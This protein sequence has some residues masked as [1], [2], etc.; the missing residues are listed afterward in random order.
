MK[1]GQEWACDDV[2]GAVLDPSLV[3]KD[4][5]LEME[6]FRSMEVYGTVPREMAYGHKII[7]TRWI[8]V[9]KGGSISLDYRSRLVGKEHNDGLDATT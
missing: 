6:N 3:E 2:S 4:R 8:D 9:N 1:D 5:E 7:R